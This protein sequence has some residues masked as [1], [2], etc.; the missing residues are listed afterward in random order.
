MD[1]LGTG[2]KIEE[3]ESDVEETTEQ[4]QEV[5]NRENKLQDAVEKL[6]QDIETSNILKEKKNERSEEKKELLERIDDYKSKVQELENQVNEAI[7]ANE[8]SASILHSL[9]LLGEEVQEGLEILADRQIVIEKCKEQ[10]KE[11]MEKLNMAASFSESSSESSSESAS[12]SGESKARNPFIESLRYDPSGNGQDKKD[13]STSSSSEDTD[14]KGQQER[15]RSHTTS[16]ERDDG[17]ISSICSAWKGMMNDQSEPEE[18]DDAAVIHNQILAGSQDPCI[19]QFG[20]KAKQKDYTLE[21]DLKEVNPGFYTGDERK[22][23]NCQRCAV[24]FEA[25]LRGADVRATDRIL[26][27]TDTLPI[28]NHPDGWPSCFKNSVLIPCFG[29]TGLDTGAK[30]MSEM[31]NFGDGA[32]A[33]VRVQ[34]HNTITV[35]GPDGSKHSYIVDTSG[36]TTVLKD[37]I[38]R[39]SVNPSSIF[40]GHDL[41]DGLVTREITNPFNPNIK[42]VQLVSKKTGA[43]LAV[44]KGGGGHVFTAIQKGG[45]TIF[46][47]PQGGYVIQRPELYFVTAKSDM[48]HVMR[49]DNLEFTDRARDCCQSV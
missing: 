35:T 9:E 37:L 41:S 22:T 38:T 21:E 45:K 16:R 8:D 28:M 46:C 11:I 4:L 13:L 34:R 20:W 49:I 43:S 14:V 23:R 24:A 10:L 25:R 29:N 6:Q 33:I 5:H 48:T 31:K 26:N 1:I 36:G 12:N 42:E 27:G 19:S 39:N 32:R 44:V 30:V 18:A 17:L 15:E 47:E 3:I 40:P 7:E 2:S